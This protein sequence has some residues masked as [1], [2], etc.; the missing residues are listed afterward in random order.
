MKRIGDLKIMT[1]RRISIFSL[2]AILITL[3]A[4][5]VPAG[6]G[7]ADAGNTNKIYL[8]VVIR[9]CE[10]KIPWQASS[11][12]NNET[13]ILAALNEQRRKHGVPE[14]QSNASLTQIARFHSRDMANSGVLEHRGS[15]GEEWYER[16]NWICEQFTWSGEI[17]GWGTHSNVDSMVNWWMNSPTHKPLVLNSDYEVAG[18]GYIYRPGSKWQHFWTVD[19]GRVSNPLALQGASAFA[20]PRECTVT[21]YEWEDG[22]MMATICD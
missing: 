8:P 13:R 15:A 6:T 11:D 16:Y 5:L 21:I 4:T 18:V 12:E 3:L 17:I 14:L 2:F 22:G 20:E 7:S 10:N 19:F 1:I 9:P